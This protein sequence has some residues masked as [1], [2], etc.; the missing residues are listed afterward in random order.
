ML[1]DK[2][3][4]SI[5][6]RWSEQGNDEYSYLSQVIICQDLANALKHEGVIL[7]CEFN[8]NEYNFIEDGDYY[9]IPIV[10]GNIDELLQFEYE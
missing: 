8:P 6:Q 5:N 4:A 2:L 1:Y 3:L 10:A 7:P 9:N